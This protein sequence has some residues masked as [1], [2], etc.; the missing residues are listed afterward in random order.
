MKG[1]APQSLTI[2]QPLFPSLN[3]WI[4]MQTNL[5]RVSEIAATAEHMVND[6]TEAKASV[7]LFRE[8]DRDSDLEHDDLAVGT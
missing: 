8:H 5:H 7:K 1:T 2:D 6:G 4:Q 3:R